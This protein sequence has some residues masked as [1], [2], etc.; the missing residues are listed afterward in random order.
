MATTYVG[1]SVPRL[2]AL[3]KV[4]GIAVYTADIEIPGMLYGA[5]LRSTLPHAR[6]SGID[7]SLAKKMPGVRA[8]VTGRDFPF[9][10]GTMIKDQPFLALEKIR[11]IGEPVVAVA[12]DT[13]ALAQEAVSKNFPY[14]LM[15]GAN[16][17]CLT[18]D[19]AVDPVSGFPEFR[20]LLCNI[21]ATGAQADG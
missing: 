21:K 17:N 14:V 12:A 7:T 3:D 20:A 5:V 19:M 1:K 4:T 8:V 15:T 13:E 16:A 9:L 10:F 2:D 11:Y 6:I 18:D